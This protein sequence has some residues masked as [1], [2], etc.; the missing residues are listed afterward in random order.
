MLRKRTGN[1][2]ISLDID[3]DCVKAVAGKLKAGKIYLTGFA[4]KKY[5]TKPELAKAIKE[6]LTATASEKEIKNAVVYSTISGS[7]LCTRVVKLPVMP[8]EELYQVVKSK[9]SK[10]VSVDMEQIVFSFF[11]LG[12]IEERGTKKLEVVF[13]AIQ[14]PLLDEYEKLF[15]YAGIEPKVL[16]TVCFSGWNL[17]KKTGREKD[18]TSLMLIDI[19]NQGTDITVYKKDR[20]VFTRDISIG[21]S[22]FIDIMKEGLPGALNK[23]ENINLVWNEAA[24]TSPGTKNVAYENVKGMLEAEALV[25]SKEIE[26]TLDHYYQITHGEKIDRCI[27]FGESSAIKEL[28]NFLKQKLKIPAECLDFADLPIELTAEKKEEFKN[29]FAFYTKPLAALFTSADQLNLAKEIRKGTKKGKT[30]TRLFPQSKMFIGIIIMFIFISVTIFAILKGLNLYYQNQIRAYKVRQDKL[31]SWVLQGIETK[32]KMDV[33]DGEKKLFQQLVKQYPAYL[34][35]ITEICNCVPLGKIELDKLEFVSQEGAD[36]NK[37]RSPLI[38][39]TVHGKVLEDDSGSSELTRFV[40]QLEKSG[41]VENISAT[42]TELIPDKQ[43]GNVLLD[44]GVKVVN[45]MLHGNVRIK[46]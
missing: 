12:E 9:V 32:R 45:F 15:K 1:I 4:G 30:L 16:T 8:Y 2:N 43:Y 29:N 3:S 40:L 33:L 7:K 46:D 28:T 22:N 23:D 5:S 37:E 44:N 13:V 39:V 42:A 14:R 10:Y 11:V 18:I 27:I 34:T 6:V 41:Y 36:R 24:Q 19:E 31:E 17:I 21:G 35:I 25:L 38:K 20:I 26:L